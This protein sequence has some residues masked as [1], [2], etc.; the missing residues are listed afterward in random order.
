MNPQPYL[1]NLIAVCGEA[2]F[3]S[4]Y[5]KTGHFPTS[6]KELSCEFYSSQNGEK[7]LLNYTMDLLKKMEIGEKDVSD[8]AQPSMQ[9]VK[10][11]IKSS[12]NAHTS[13]SSPQEYNSSD[14]Q[15]EI[16]HRLAV[17]NYNRLETAKALDGLSTTSCVQTILVN[18][19]QL[20]KALAV[21]P[22]AHLV[23]DT[24]LPKDSLAVV[25][26]GTC[27]TDLVTKRRPA[28][29]MGPEQREKK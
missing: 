23:L 18:S 8:M 17:C 14:R 28:K 5:K 6:E 1:E 4:D 20:L 15:E 7:T 21:V 10:A 2:W 11:Y 13:S 26:K 24:N 12:K 29:Y 16:R 19:M 22:K 9:M 3:L 25:F 27:T